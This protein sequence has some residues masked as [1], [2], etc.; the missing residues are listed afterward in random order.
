MR[1]VSFELLFVITL[2]SA[3]QRMKYER[4]G[5]RPRT[6]ESCLLEQHVSFFS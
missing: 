3:P 4:F 1:Y 5:I 6:D 2:T